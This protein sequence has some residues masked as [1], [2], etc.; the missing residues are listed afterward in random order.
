MKTGKRYSL[1]SPGSRE[2][3]AYYDVHIGKH[4]LTIAQ[5]IMIRDARISA[6]NAEKAEKQALLQKTAKRRTRKVKV[7]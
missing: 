4:G 3:G 7:S 2:Q 1:Y 5:R 6:R